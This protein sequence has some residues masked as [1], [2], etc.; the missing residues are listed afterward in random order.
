MKVTGGGD[1]TQKDL[2]FLSFS[3]IFLRWEE[4]QQVC[5]LRVVD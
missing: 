3:F 2:S 4:S 5:L 1:G